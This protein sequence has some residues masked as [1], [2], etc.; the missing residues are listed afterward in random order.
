[1]QRGLTRVKS[2]HAATRPLAALSSR[3]VINFNA[4]AK[5]KP[6]IE[7]GVS[8]FGNTDA[9]SSIVNA[10]SVAKMSPRMMMRIAESAEESSAFLRVGDDKVHER[11]QKGSV[12]VDINTVLGRASLQMFDP[13]SVENTNQSINQDLLAHDG[14]YSHV[15]T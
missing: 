1:M 13:H 3:K 11:D 4:V 7:S 6:D 12:V 10:E 9:N 8:T 14:T 2:Q 5:Q 15:N